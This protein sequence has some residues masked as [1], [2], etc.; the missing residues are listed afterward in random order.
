MK[1]SI[2]TMATRWQS[3]ERPLFKGSL[4]DADGCKCAQ[5]DVLFC[6]GYTDEQLRSMSQSKADSET[7]KLLGISR[8]HAVLLRDINDS[9][10]G[11]P[12][13]VLT[14]PERVLGEKATILLAFWL[15][16]DNMSGAAWSAAWSAARDA[17]GDAAWSTAGRAAG[18]AARGAAGDATRGVDWGAAGGAARR[19][20]GRAT[21]EIQGMDI[22]ER[23]GK[24]PYFLAFFGFDTWEKVRA[25]THTEVIKE[26]IQ[27]ESE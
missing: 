1:V 25:L 15:H 19:A 27:N 26:G 24:Y 17:D 16:L 7:A 8:T 20:A 11:S 9:V 13:D 5:G 14:D 18:C 2:E 23:D 3:L 12:Q 21:Y 4:I 6:G 22:L 10:D